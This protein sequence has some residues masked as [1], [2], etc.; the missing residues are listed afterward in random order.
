MGDASFV[1]GALTRLSGQTTNDIACKPNTAETI[2]TMKCV[3]KRAKQRNEPDKYAFAI[4]G[5]LKL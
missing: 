5:T 2:E 4:I 1:D 3:M